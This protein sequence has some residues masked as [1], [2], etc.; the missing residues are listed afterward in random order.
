M[1]LSQT[2]YSVG[3]A[4]QTVVAPTNDFAEY[5]LKNIQ[6]ANSSEYARDGHIYLLA[7]KFSV[8]AGAATSF[9]VM[10]GPYGAQLDF[11]E[12][13]SDVSSIY[14]QLI[15]GATVVTTGSHIAAYNLN[16]NVS[17]SHAAVLKATTSVTGGTVISAELATATNQAGG[18]ISSNK[19]HT[20]EANTEYVMKFENVGNQTTNVFFQLGFSEQYNGFNSVWLGTPDASFVLRAGEELKL[21]LPPNATINAT[22]KHDGCKLAVI[23]QE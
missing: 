20:L 7:A 9:S 15:E 10:T 23:R 12:I 13:V 6:P 16:R 17:D 3:T 11:Y 2:V 5:V 1:A 21:T 22:A 8:T 14:A 19:V 18:A 4:T